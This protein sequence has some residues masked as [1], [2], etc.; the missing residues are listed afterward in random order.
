[1]ER[2]WQRQGLTWDFPPPTCEARPRAD[3]GR[4]DSWLLLRD[5]AAEHASV[6]QGSASSR[7]A[8]GRP[9]PVVSNL[10]AGSCNV[11]VGQR[12]ARPCFPPGAA[13]AAHTC[14]LLSPGEPARSETGMGARPGTGCLNP[15]PATAPSP[16]Q[17]A[18]SVSC[19][20]L[21]PRSSHLASGPVSAA[22]SSFLPRALAPLTLADTGQRALLGALPLPLCSPNS[23]PPPLRFPPPPTC[24]HLSELLQYSKLVPHN[25]AFNYI[26]V[27]NAF[28]FHLSHLLR[29]LHDE[30]TGGSGGRICRN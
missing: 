13:L 4:R 10:L 3:D 16:A 17:A 25:L 18:A 27:C 2:W 5:V 19:P 14:R 22:A 26:L 20:P 8:E 29:T 1:M 12:G 30:H 15:P 7:G 9:L 6:P 11:H 24:T 23:R 28:S 21:F